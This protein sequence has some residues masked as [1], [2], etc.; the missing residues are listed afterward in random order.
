MTALPSPFQWRPMEELTAPGERVR[1]RLPGWK[2]RDVIGWL[3]VGGIGPSVRTF[4]SQ[5]TWDDDSLCGAP[6]HR[7]EPVSWQSIPTPD[8]IETWRRSQQ[9][10][11]T[12]VRSAA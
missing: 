9:P 10:A 2:S 8:V 5:Q 6:T 7:I 11:D 3:M 1:M 4:W 12:S